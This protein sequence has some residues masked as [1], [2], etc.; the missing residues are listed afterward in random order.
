M[1]TW[2]PGDVISL[3]VIA[4]LVGAFVLLSLVGSG[5]LR[6]TP[7]SERFRCCCGRCKP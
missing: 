5:V 6:R 7:R 3:V 2:T 4:P 1:A